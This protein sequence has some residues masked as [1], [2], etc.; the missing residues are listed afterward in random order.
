MVRTNIEFNTQKRIEAEKN[1]DEDGKAL[2]RL[3]NN[4]TYGKRM[5]NGQLKKQN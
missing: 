1:N 5:N 3:M 2:H 4:A